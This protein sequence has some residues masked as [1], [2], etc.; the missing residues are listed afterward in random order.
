MKSLAAFMRAVTK[1]GAMPLL[2]SVSAD[3]LKMAKVE[4]YYEQFIADHPTKNA[5]KSEPVA[6]SS[7]SEN[8]GKTGQ[9]KSSAKSTATEDADKSIRSLPDT[10]TL[11]RNKVPK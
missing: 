9:L 1:Q 2:S 11:R 10:V 6:K 7:K 4:G 3:K 5:G 8:A